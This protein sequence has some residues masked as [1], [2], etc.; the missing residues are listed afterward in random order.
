MTTNNSAEALAAGQLTDEDVNRFCELAKISFSRV[1]G[2]LSPTVLA[3]EGQ[4]KNRT[5]RLKKTDT[6]IQ[7]H[8]VSGA[9]MV[10]GHWVTSAYFGGGPVVIYDSMAPRVDRL[11][12]NQQ[13]RR[14]LVDMYGHVAKDKGGD[15]LVKVFEIPYQVGDVDC[16]LFAIAY[17]TE[18]LFGDRPEMRRFE[19]SFMRQHLTNSFNNGTL[20]KFPSNAT[21]MAPSQ[22]VW[23]A[24]W[25][26]FLRKEK[27][28]KWVGCTSTR[29]CSDGWF[30]TGCLVGV[31]IDRVICLKCSSK[32]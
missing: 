19:Q 21:A 29:K 23:L 15:F 17:A 12:L 13:F 32:R 18:I 26:C 20:L 7:I 3:I 27:K 28:D 8:Y 14:Q 25:C 10:S 9:S 31:Y 16:G 30:H 24:C 6:I 1:K 11:L 2:L 4:A 22:N 5:A